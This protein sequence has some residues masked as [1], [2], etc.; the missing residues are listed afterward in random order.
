MYSATLPSLDMHGIAVDNTGNAYVTGA[1]ILG[2]QDLP[3]TTPGAYRSSHGD[4]ISCGDFSSDIRSAG[5]VW[6]LNA[7]GSAPVMI[8]YLDDCDHGEAIA[9]D[10]SGNIYV[11]GKTGDRH[12]ATP[13][14]FQPTLSG[15]VDCFITVLNPS[16]TAVKYSTYYGGQFV[17]NIF[18]LLST[19]TQSEYYRLHDSFDLPVH[20]AF[21]DGP[22]NSS[23]TGYVAKFNSTLSQLDF[24]HV[25]GGTGNSAIGVAED[26]HGRTFIAEAPT[27][28]STTGHFREHALSQ[29]TFPMYRD[30]FVAAFN[31]DGTILYSSWIGARQEKRRH[32]LRY[33]K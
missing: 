3:M 24:R 15:I 13:G 21:Q 23:V 5:F 14:A 29:F 33:C 28:T 17:D 8:T 9:L 6:E 10:K 20:N 26:S 25:P 30:T 12:F 27:A 1:V 7:S 16:G 32:R 2:V 11:A 22:V 4:L 18:G 19:T 31:A